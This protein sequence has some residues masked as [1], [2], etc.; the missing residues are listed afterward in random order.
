ML[1]D[2]YTQ[3][4][5]EVYVV[6]PLLTTSSHA[7]DVEKRQSDRATDIEKFL[8]SSLVT[9]GPQSL[10]YVRLCTK[11]CGASPYTP[12]QISFGSIFWSTEP[13]KIWT[14][15]DVLIERHIPFVRDDPNTLVSAT[16]Y[17]ADFQPRVSLCDGT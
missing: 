4:K 10:V 13:E 3:E 5:R 8:N 6:G 12:S 16:D 14:F 2:W 1:R 15:L 7:L 11:T 9:H 17:L